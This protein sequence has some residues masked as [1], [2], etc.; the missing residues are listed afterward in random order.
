MGHS[1][2]GLPSKYEGR[3]IWNYY[4]LLNVKRLV[5]GGTLFVIVSEPLVDKSQTQTVYK[6][7]N[8]SILIPEL[9]KHFWYHV[10]NDLIAI[11]TNGLYITYPD[12]NEILSCQLSAGHYC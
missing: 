12:S 7:H 6:I 10:P 2:L 3:G 8:L 4:R 11:I 1:K 5:Y 9:C